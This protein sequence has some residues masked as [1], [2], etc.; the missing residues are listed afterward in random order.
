MFRL[1]WPINVLHPDT[2]ALYS[3]DGA[4]PQSGEHLAIPPMA[5]LLETYA[6]TGAASEFRN[7]L[8]GEFGRTAGGSLTAEDL[9]AKPQVVAPRRFEVTLGDDRWEVLGSPRLGGRLIE[10]IVSALA[11]FD[12]EAKSPSPMETALALANACRAGHRAK[13]PGSLLGGTT[14]ISTLDQYGGAA[15]LTLTNGEGC[16]YLVPQTGVQMNNCLSY[17]F[18]SPRDRQHSR[19]LPP[20]LTKNM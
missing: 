3:K 4:P 9:V 7:R 20:A 8:L 1:L 16:G 19:T 15:S 12:A 10:V 17:T 11:A 2:C 6:K 18:L 5:A 13:D 14:H